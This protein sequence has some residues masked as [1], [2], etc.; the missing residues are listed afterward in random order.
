MTI[1]YLK[2]TLAL[3]GLLASACATHVSEEASTDALT[4][5]AVALADCQTVAAECLGATP[6]GDQVQ[7]CRG[8]LRACLDAAIEQ[9]KADVD[10]LKPCAQQARTC[11]S[12]ASSWEEASACREAFTACAGEVVDLPEL[13]PPELT[14]PELPEAVSG[15]LAGVG[16]CRDTAR[17]CVAAADGDRTATAACASAFRSCMRGTV[18]EAVKEAT[19]GAVDLDAIEACNAEARTCAEGAED[20][21]PCI[22]GWQAC[23][24]IELPEAPS[25][26]ELQACQAE[27][28]ACFDGMPTREGARAC[29]ESLAGCLGLELP[30]FDAG[31]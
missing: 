21:G 15:V 16:A 18:S 13:T 2:H 31:N 28:R 25:A 27:A 29:G 14:L 24:G 6:S 19:D 23:Q 11:A 10:A 8:D 12:E 22:E 26:D 20:I 17:E 7:Q 9:A 30:A 4:T 1:K 5:Q 3:G